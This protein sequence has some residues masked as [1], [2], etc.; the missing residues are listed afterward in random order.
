MTIAHPGRRTSALRAVRAERYWEDRLLHRSLT[1][2]DRGFSSFS[3]LGRAQ[4]P[5]AVFMEQ[6][7]KRTHVVAVRRF[8]QLSRMPVIC[9]RSA[10]PPGGAALAHR[11]G[12]DGQ[13]ASKR[14]RKRTAGAKR[15]C[16]YSALLS[17]ARN[18]LRQPLCPDSGR[19]RAPFKKHPSRDRTR[20]GRDKRHAS[21][22]SGLPRSIQ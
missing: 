3:H 7:G 19:C 6:G 18:R 10:W 16:V 17:R 8:S 9:W 12:R 5:S 4:N 13:E 11:R 1:F 22:A 20:T 2:L 21:P 14:E 15:I